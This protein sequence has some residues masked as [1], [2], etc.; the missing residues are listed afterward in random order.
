MISSV[1]GQVA[2]VELDHAVV[3]VGGVGL[4][5]HAVPATLATLRRGEQARLATS[6][7]VREDSLTL[8]GFADAA[9]RELFVLLQ[10]VPGVGPR[11]ALAML[12]VLEPD[13]LRRALA[14]GDITVLTRVPGIGRK[15]ADRLV[16]ELRDKVGG[17]APAASGMTPRG[18]GAVRT[19]V[20]E[21]LVG[22]GFAVR[23]AEQAVDAVLA[24]ADPDS[25]N[26]S[27]VLRRALTR[28]GRNQ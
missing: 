28:L 21:A 27:E 1:R 16:V 11:L 13:T 9:A 17:L 3:E 18:G 8:Y 12:A 14:D 7:V 26:N 20:A 2:S 24:D 4:A 10:T 15:G 25:F 5:V 19:Q 23:Q 6:L 22:L